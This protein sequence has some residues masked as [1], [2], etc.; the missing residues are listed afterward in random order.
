VLYNLVLYPLNI[1][2]D[3]VKVEG[4]F[5][6]Y[7]HE[8]QRTPF[9]AILEVKR[10]VR[11]IT[12]NETPLPKIIWV[13]DAQIVDGIHVDIAHVSKLICC[14]I[15]EFYKELEDDLLLGM[16]EYNLNRDRILYNKSRGLLDDNLHDYR[17]G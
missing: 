11:A 1:G 7:V 16:P 10:L 9:A 17:N 5:L 8:D 14:S 12:K 4:E 15:R 3:V 6:S 13:G 2:D